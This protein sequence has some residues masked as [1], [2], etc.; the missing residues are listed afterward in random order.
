[1]VYCWGVV[2]VSWGLDLVLVYGSYIVVNGGVG[3]FEIYLL[4]CYWM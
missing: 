3:K 4:V 1:M 2:W